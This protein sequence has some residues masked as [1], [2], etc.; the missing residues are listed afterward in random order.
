M[1]HLI[2]PISFRLGI[3]RLWNHSWCV[4]NIFEYNYLALQQANIQSFLKKFFEFKIFPRK[5]YLYSHVNLFYFSKYLDI[6]IYVFK[7][8]SN[9]NLKVFHMRK[10]SKLLLKFFYKTM[11]YKVVTK[12][13]DFFYFYFSFFRLLI[14]QFQIKLL[15]NIYLRKEFLLVLIFILLKCNRFLNF[16]NII[17][18]FIFFK[19]NLKNKR[20]NFFIKKVKVSF[21]RKLSSKNNQKFN[22]IF[23]NLVLK[24]FFWFLKF[25]FWKK[26][27]FFLKFFLKKFTNSYLM[28]R[29]CKINYI[30]INLNVIGTYIIKRLKQ[31][32]KVV[33]LILPV[34]R[35]LRKN[36]N[37]LGFK[38]SFCGRFS[39][40]EMATTEFFSHAAVSFNTLSF[41]IDY[42]LVGVILKDSFCGIKIWLNRRRDKFL[43]LFFHTNSL[44]WKIIN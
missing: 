23:N 34:I 21:K 17:N 26:I 30:G 41:F 38:F 15:N 42:A 12:L 13:K 16:Y 40:K 10:L 2:N 7:T 35:N 9:L 43:D 5:G 8:I 37:L 32:F 4:A 33:E 19:Y 44:I 14:F 28:L 39:R 36:K 11:F 31:R 29:I 3:N 20:R 24:V 6:R 18:L 25:K 27:S 22:K 1:G